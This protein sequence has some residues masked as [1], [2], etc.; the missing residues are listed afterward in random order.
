MTDLEINTAFAV[1]RGWKWVPDPKC[2]HPSK[3]KWWL[4]PFED[5][6]EGYCAASDSALPDYSQ[7]RNLMHGAIMTLD[8]D[9][10]SEFLTQ[11]IIVCC[12][13][14][15]LEQ[16]DDYR[17]VIEAPARKQAEAYLRAKG[18]WV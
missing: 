4:P 13:K 1:D 15:H 3:T 2:L 12:G 7:D 5:L 10:Y 11:L 16:V 9:D 8:A 14:N 17:K 6:P 18:K